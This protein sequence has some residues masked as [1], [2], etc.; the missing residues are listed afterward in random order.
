MEPT[1]AIELIDKLTSFL[2]TDFVS[3]I[4]AIF[5]TEGMRVT[6]SC[7]GSSYFAVMNGEISEADSLI[8]DSYRV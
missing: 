4:S 3:R 7:S 6:D 1:D 8:D 2:Q 5:E